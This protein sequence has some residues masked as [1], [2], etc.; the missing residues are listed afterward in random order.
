M[1]AA[2]NETEALRQRV[3]ELE[4]ERKVLRRASRY[5]LHALE[6]LLEYVDNSDGGWD[7]AVDAHEALDTVVAEAGKE[8]GGGE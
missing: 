1:T 2:D 6:A 3:A 7:F 5:A 8:A 4:G